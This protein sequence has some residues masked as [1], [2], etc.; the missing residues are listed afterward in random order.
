MMDDILVNLNLVH[1]SPRVTTIFEDLED[2]G[3][4]TASVNSFVHR[5]RV[6]H[7]VARPLARRLAGRLGWLDATYGPRRLFFGELYATDVTG[8]P[9]NFGGS[10]DRHGAAV[11][12]WLVT[13][14]GF[15]FLF[16]YLYETDNAQHY[17]KDV[18]G[19]V[20]GADAAIGAAVDAAGGLD[21]FLERYAILVVADHGQSPVHEV[22]DPAEALAGLEVFRSSRRG[23]V[24]RADVALAASNRVV[25]A[26][27]LPNGREPADALARRLGALP[28]ADVVA[29]R[30]EG[31]H[32]VRRGGGELRFARGGRVEDARGNTWTVEG[33]AD[34]LPD[35]A[36]PNP[37]ERLEGILDCPRAGDVVVSAA[38]GWE[39]ADAGGSHHRGGGSHG[40][41]TAEDS[42]VPLVWA[43]FDSAPDLPPRPSITDLAPLARSFFGVGAPAPAAAVT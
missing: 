34:L 7:P 38:P 16:L 20:E 22:A 24:R 15:D 39:F 31:R 29:V 5:G 12:R 3:L 9:R 40:S 41:L 43:G 13:R 25:M 33:D 8:A 18:M 27:R 30:G 35:D 14:D 23:D 19:A 1:M 28:A 32:V 36:Y 26:Y 6:R 4:V 17:G 21:A 2:A 37:L 42:L 11:A 10:V